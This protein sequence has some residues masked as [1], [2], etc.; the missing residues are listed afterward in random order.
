[1]LSSDA[2]SSSMSARVKQHQGAEQMGSR[3]GGEDADR[4]RHRMADED[5]I[6]EFERLAQLHDIGRVARQG[7]VPLR[8]VG[9]EIRTASAYVIEQDDAIAVPEPID[10]EPPHVLIA[11]KAMREHHRLG[12]LGPE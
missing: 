8:I 4:R 2:S 9:V 10:H 7:A 11:A 5:G 12:V 6:A 3:R 1:L